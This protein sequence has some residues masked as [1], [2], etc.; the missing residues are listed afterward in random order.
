MLG[1]TL[2]V[3]FS[4]SD[5]CRESSCVSKLV[6]DFNTRFIDGWLVQPTTREIEGFVESHPRQW[7]DR[8]GPA[9]SKASRGPLGIPP[10]AVGGSFRSCL[11]QGEPRASWNPTH[12]RGWDLKE[13][14]RCRNDCMTERYVELHARSAFSFLEGASL[15]E[16]LIHVCAEFGGKAMALLD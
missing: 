5:L 15:P 11:Q 4:M 3:K 9:Y 12:C 2:I 14:I 10:T 6:L 8:S 1:A 7:V 13:L 16:E